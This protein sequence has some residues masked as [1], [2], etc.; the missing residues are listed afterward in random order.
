MNTVKDFTIGQRVSTD[1]GDGTVSKIGRKYVYV[2]IDGSDKTEQ[3]LPGELSEL[4]PA[5]EIP[6]VEDSPEQPT[7]VVFDEAHTFQADAAMVALVSN[8]VR[9]DNRPP[10]RLKGNRA[11]TGSRRAAR[12]AQRKSRRANRR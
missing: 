5:D 10:M 11:S 3:M 8:A 1:L 6:A 2:D 4:A 9:F 12:K 7:V